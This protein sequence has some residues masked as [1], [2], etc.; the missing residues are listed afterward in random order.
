M[1]V[2]P[3]DSGWEVPTS[4]SDGYSDL[5]QINGVHISLLR[6]GPMHA[7]VTEI[8]FEESVDNDTDNCQKVFYDDCNGTN[9]RLKITVPDGEGETGFTVKVDP[10]KFGG[11]NWG[12]IQ[13]TDG[14]DGVQQSAAVSVSIGG[15]DYK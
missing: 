6:F 14:T 8:W 3:R 12:R 10:G 2:D 7:D 11:M 13:L 1:P 5:I 15:R 9:S 4:D